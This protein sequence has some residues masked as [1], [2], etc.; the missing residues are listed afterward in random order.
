MWAAVERVVTDAVAA[1]YAEPCAGVSAVAAGR[2]VGAAAESRG[3]ER[4]VFGQQAAALVAQTPMHFLHV[5]TEVAVREICLGDHV[6]PGGDVELLLELLLEGGL[7]TC[8][9]RRELLLGHGLPLPHRPNLRNQA[10]TALLQVFRIFL[11]LVGQFAHV[12]EGLIGRSD[13]LVCP[14]NAI[15][16]SAEEIRHAT[17]GAKAHAVRDIR[18]AREASGAAHMM[19]QGCRGAAEHQRKAQPTSQPSTVD[20]LPM[21]AG[22]GGELHLYLGTSLWR[23]G[24]PVALQGKHGDRDLHQQALLRGQLA[25]RGQAGGCHAAGKCHGASRRHKQGGCTSAA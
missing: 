8:I 24:L 3:A 4:E 15:G 22:C 13:E 12:L 10:H 1:A 18:C 5:G 21:A 25:A 14:P 7:L 17:K 16:Q 23:G 11:K 2:L 6:L 9:H 20:Q 19:T